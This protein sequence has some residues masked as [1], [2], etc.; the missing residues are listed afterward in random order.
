MRFLLEYLLVTTFAE[1]GGR[2]FLVA[3]T[4]VDFFSNM[5]SARSACAFV[6]APTTDCRT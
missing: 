6:R 5:F 2:T 4:V 1:F 3:T